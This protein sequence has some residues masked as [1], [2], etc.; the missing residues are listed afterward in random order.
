MKWLSVLLLS[1]LMTMPARADEH[2]RVVAFLVSIMNH[3]YEDDN[4]AGLELAKCMMQV[5]SKH[6]NPQQYRVNIYDEHPDRN[7]ASY[8][9]ITVYN[10]EGLVVSCT[11][12][13][14]ETIDIKQCTGKK[15]VPLTPGKE[16]PI[17]Q[18]DG[19]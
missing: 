17:T 15:I 16:M 3:C 18:P 14:K 8:F 12:I 4:K 11:G 13:A 10:K 19:Q 6:N 7:V 5:L 1:L 2:T 9:K